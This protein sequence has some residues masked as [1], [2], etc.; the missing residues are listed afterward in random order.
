MQKCALQKDFGSTNQ[1]GINYSA[2]WKENYLKIL[3]N[4]HNR[5]DGEEII[6]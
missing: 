4:S 5:S 2:K 3:D 6:Q 1:E